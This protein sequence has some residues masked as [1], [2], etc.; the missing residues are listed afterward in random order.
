MVNVFENPSA[1]AERSFEQKSEVLK[2]AGEK[3][4]R[5]LDSMLKKGEIKDGAA[6]QA[7]R[8]IQEGTLRI[9]SGQDKAE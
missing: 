9:V 5:A 8:A 1:G 4:I 2:Q 6:V 7:L 3:Q